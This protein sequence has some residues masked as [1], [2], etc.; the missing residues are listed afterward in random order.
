MTGGGGLGALLGGGG[1]GDGVSAERES[2]AQGWEPPRPFVESWADV[3]RE[4]PSCL[5]FLLDFRFLFSSFPSLSDF[6]PFSSLFFPV[7]FLCSV[8][9]FPL[10]VS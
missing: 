5:P 2:P 10:S 9:L 4:P 8:L 3:M 7:F 1:A 6:F